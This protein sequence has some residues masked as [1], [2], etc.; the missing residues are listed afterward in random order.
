LVQ[1]GTIAN[2]DL[3]KTMLG[4]ALQRP[5]STQVTGIGQ[6]IDIDNG[7]VTLGKPIENKIGPDKTGTTCD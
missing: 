7:L 6:L 2:V 1:R 4:I 5:E 3:S